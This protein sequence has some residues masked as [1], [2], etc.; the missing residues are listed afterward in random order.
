MRSDSSR[1]LYFMTE[2]ILSNCP[3]LLNL[4]LSCAKRCEL[5]DERQYIELQ[6]E[7]L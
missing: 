3:R 2:I 4:L 7:N 6:N 5:A 1:S